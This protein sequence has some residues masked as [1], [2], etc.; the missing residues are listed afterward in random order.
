MKQPTLKDNQTFHN[1]YSR[2][3]LHFITKKLE[4]NCKMLLF[5]LVKTEHF[6]VKVCN[7]MLYFRINK[8]GK[9]RVCKL[10]YLLGPM[11]TV[12]GLLSMDMVR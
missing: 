12:V 1:Y 2:R 8:H 5:K 6:N 10:L 9:I 3:Q 4:S 7:R 11:I